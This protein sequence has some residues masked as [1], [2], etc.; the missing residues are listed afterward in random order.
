MNTGETLLRWEA[1]LCHLDADPQIY[2]NIRH[3]VTGFL[4]DRLP[5]TCKYLFPTSFATSVMFIHRIPPSLFPKLIVIGRHTDCSPI[6]GLWMYA[7]THSGVLHP[8]VSYT[9]VNVGDFTSCRYR[10]NTSGLVNHIVVGIAD[11]HALPN[12]NTA[13]ICDIV[14][15]WEAIWRIVEYREISNIRR[16]KCQNLNGSHLGLQLSLHNISKPSVKWR[17]KM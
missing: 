14:V 9:G 7:V 8:C 6:T 1:S 3:N 16:T 12:P 4:G 5:R 2:Q 10:C 17:M 15:V 13:V 11:R